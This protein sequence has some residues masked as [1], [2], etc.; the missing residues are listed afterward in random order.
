MG[1]RRLSEQRGGVRGLLHQAAGPA[2]LTRPPADVGCR[3]VG[4]E[5]SRESGP[6]GQ[7]KG[8]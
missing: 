3:K 1:L 4:E 5:T 7:N 2:R 6:S 8:E